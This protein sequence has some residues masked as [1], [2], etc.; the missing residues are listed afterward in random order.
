MTRRGWIAI[1]CLLL[2]AAGCSRPTVSPLPAATPTVASASPTTPS[3]SATPTTP[4]ASPT[5]SIT[6]TPT[7]VATPTPTPSATTT[8][9]PAVQRFALD[10]AAEFDDGLII[11]I[12]GSVADKAKKTDKGAAA[13]KGQIVIAS[14]RIEN[15]TKHTYDATP[16]QITATY[17]TGTSAELIVDKTGELQP[18]F[19]GKVKPNDESIATVG[20]AVPYSQLK[21]V[22]FIVDPS[23]PEH[24]PVSFT[25]KVRRL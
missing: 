6:P 18:G 9:P 1:G 14:V 20:F 2:T 15:G 22:T 5:A 3:P 4:S 23:D 24:D 8:T 10:Q 13:T 12:A 7:P 17:G 25:G 21:R 11:E 19:A 16:V